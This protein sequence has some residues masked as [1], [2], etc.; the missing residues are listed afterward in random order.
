MPA[1]GIGICL[2]LGEV[3]DETHHAIDRGGGK[4]ALSGE[5]NAPLWVW[6]LAE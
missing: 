3:D 4:E 6:W 2:R 5:R 1:T